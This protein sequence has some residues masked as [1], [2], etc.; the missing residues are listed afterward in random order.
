MRTLLMLRIT[1]LQPLFHTELVWLFLRFLF[2]G[3]EERVIR[4]LQVGLAYVLRTRTHA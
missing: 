4:H 1:K 2:R 3:I